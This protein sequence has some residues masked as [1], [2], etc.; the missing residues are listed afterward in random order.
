MQRGLDHAGQGRPGDSL[1]LGNGQVGINLWVEAGGD[2]HFYIS[3]TDSLSEISRLLK[4]GKVRVSLSPNPFVAGKPFRQTLRLRSGCCEIVAGEN[5]KEV[6]L[7]VFVN[8][9][10]PVVY[11]KGKSAAPVSIKVVNET[12][13]A[14]K[15]VLPKEEDRSA[16]SVHDAPFDLVESAGGA[17]RRI[18]GRGG[19]VSPQRGVGVSADDK[20]P[21]ALGSGQRG[22]R[23]VAAWAA[24]RMDHGRWISGQRRSNAGNAV[25]AQFVRRS[26][27]RA[28]RTTSNVEKWLAAAETIADGSAE[29]VEGA[30][31]DRGLVADV[32]GAVVGFC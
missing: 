31:A 13:P 25:A 30:A 1:P 11:V 28:V 6:A 9:K 3:R 20:A 10:R 4:V 18:D 22:A 19:V 29:D 17:F 7:F 8:P 23:S 26:R 32:L 12:W 14:A 27:R 16:W 24:W 5:G 15:R 2:L 21:R